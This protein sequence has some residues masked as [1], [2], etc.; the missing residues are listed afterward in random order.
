MR[1]PVFID[2][3]KEECLKEGVLE[4]YQREKE[5]EQ[6]YLAKHPRWRVNWYKYV[7]L[8]TLIVAIWAITCAIMFLGLHVLVPTVVSAAVYVTLGFIIYR[9]G[10][11]DDY[12]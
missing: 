9:F 11:K 1:R 6:R 12:K 2:E 4:K 10:F 7:V 5:V 3:I 8:P